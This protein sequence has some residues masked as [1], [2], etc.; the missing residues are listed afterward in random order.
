M[1]EPRYEL[2]APDVV[3]ESIDGEALIVNLRT[4]LYYSAR[5]SGDLLWRM[6]L[7]GHTSAEAAAAIGPSDTPADTVATDVARFVE[8]LVAEELVRPR[9]ALEVQRLD[10]RPLDSFEAPVLE[11]FADL[12]ELLVLDPVHDVTEE[13]WPHARPDLPRGSLT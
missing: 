12:Q 8:E 11:R 6:V 2:N 4:G 1:P 9:A 7:A 10:T 13:G 3:A 5:G